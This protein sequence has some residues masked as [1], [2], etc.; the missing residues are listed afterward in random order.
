MGACWTVR[1]VEFLPIRHIA[2]PACQ[3]WEQ[4]PPLQH[5]SGLEARLDKDPSRY[6]TL[7]ASFRSPN[8]SP[9]IHARLCHTG[10]DRI[11]ASRRHV[12]CQVQS[13]NIFFL[14]N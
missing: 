11:A 1:V 2:I 7:V 13:G 6:K 9:A 14:A 4:N 10:V 5:T 12:R 8:L 3:A